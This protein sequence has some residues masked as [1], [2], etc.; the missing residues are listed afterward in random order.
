MNTTR[1]MRSHHPFIT[2]DGED[3]SG[4]RAEVRVITGYGTIKKNSQGDDEIDDRE[5][6]C[7]YTFE[8]PNYA[9]PVYGWVQ[10][11]TDVYNR[12]EQARR[13]NTPMEYRIEIVRTKGVDRSIPFNKIPERTTN[14]HRSLAA[15]KVDGDDEWVLSNAVTR[16]DEDPV[17]DNGLISAYDHPGRPQNRTTHNQQHSPSVEPAPYHTYDRDGNFNQGSFAIQA[18]LSIYERLRDDVTK[19][20][21][22]PDRHKLHYVVKQLLIVVNTIQLDMYEGRMTKPDPT[23][24]SHTRIRAAMFSAMRSYPFSMDLVT[25]KPGK[26]PREAFDEWLSTIESETRDTISMAESIGRSLF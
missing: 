24:G 14:T 5:K 15:I 25:P 13:D 4:V 9:F 2:H 18:V 6:A 10:K 23:V 12:I 7:R 19:K 11:N 26:N 17:Y 16:F 20:G 1:P 21:Q 3:Q 22:N 8:A